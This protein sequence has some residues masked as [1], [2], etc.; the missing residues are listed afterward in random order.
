MLIILE[1]KD[2]NINEDFIPII[3]S[4]AKN[5]IYICMLLCNLFYY[6]LVGY[7]FFWLTTY[8][9]D[10]FGIAQGYAMMSFVFLLFFS[11]VAGL[12]CGGMIADRFVCDLI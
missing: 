1:N 11:I 7:V 6:M 9:H 5:K 3:K 10:T 8:I 4:L 2:Q 12:V